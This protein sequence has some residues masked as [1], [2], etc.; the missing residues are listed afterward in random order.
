MGTDAQP[1]GEGRPVSGIQGVQHKWRQREVV[2]PVYQPADLELPLV[3]G[4]DLNKHVHPVP[5][6]GGG[7]FGNEL[8]RLRNHE[9][10]RAG[11]LHRVA[12][13][14][15]T[16]HGHASG[17]HRVQDRSQIRPS[18]AGVDVDIHLLRRERGPQQ[19]FGATQGHGRERQ[20]ATRAVDLGEVRLG[21]AAREYRGHRQEHVGVARPV[22]FRHD[23]LE[24]RRGS[25]D[26]IDDWIDDGVVIPTQL[27]DVVPRAQP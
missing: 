11:L 8:E 23:V 24:L 14:V 10:A 20:S 25:R 2:D 6:G 17:G 13:R 21:R 1:T 5:A 26:V 4:V 27:P 16:D 18:G 7:E 3:V 9:A 22:P 12:H 15:Q 19:P